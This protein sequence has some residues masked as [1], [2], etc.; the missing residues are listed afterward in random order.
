MFFDDEIAFAG[1]RPNGL[2]NFFQDFDQKG[3]GAAGEIKHGDAFV[4]GQSIFD[5]ERVFQYIVDGSHD[6][7]DNRRRRI[8]DAARLFELGVIFAQKSS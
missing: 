7:I 2:E 6:E 5:A 3:S 8:I 1:I 4:V